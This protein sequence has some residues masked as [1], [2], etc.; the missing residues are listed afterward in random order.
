M[1]VETGL[2]RGFP[3][4]HP[5]VWRDPATGVAIPKGPVSNPTW[6]K[7]LL[8]DAER[9][10]AYQRALTALAAK[11]L[12]FW[13]NTFGYTY[14]VIE[15]VNGR[16]RPVHSDDAYR[17]FITWPVQDPA[18]LKIQRN[19]EE[20]K[21]LCIDKSRDMGASWLLVSTFVWFWLFR[22]DSKFLIV[23]RKEDLV[24]KP[25]DSDSLFWKMDMLVRRLPWWMRPNLKRASMHLENRQNGAVIDGESTNENIGRGGRRTAIA[26]DEAAAIPKLGAAISA[27]GPAAGCLIYNSTPMGPGAYS[28]VRFSGMDVVV[29]GYW[30]HP[31]KGQGREVRFDPRVGREVWWTPWYEAEWTEQKRSRKYMAQ[32]VLIDHMTSGT[33]VFDSDVLNRQLSACR[34]PSWR[35]RIEMDVDRVGDLDQA[36]RRGRVGDI[37]L[38]EDHN[39]PLR[40]WCELE[41]DEDGILRPRQDLDYALGG[42]VALGVSASNSALSIGVCNWR[43]KIGE[44][45]DANT[46]PDDL[47]RVAVMLAL[48]LGGRGGGAL[49][50]WERNGPGGI[51]T[52]RIKRIGYPRLDKDRDPVTPTVKTK[53]AYGFASTGHSKEVILGELNGDMASGQFQNPSEDALREAGRYVYYETGGVGPAQM[54][55]ESAD[56]TATHGDRVIAD[57]VLNRAM[58]RSGRVKPGKMKY[59]YGSPGW[60]IAKEE[61]E[62]AEAEEE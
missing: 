60:H 28:D 39:G 47:A 41:E 24:D 18:L 27:A 4:E 13:I 26:F 49:V 50:S 40:L 37:E 7:S 9:D 34:P 21:P 8:I 29:L 11:S 6:R 48:W 30:D 53:N 5:A 54:E 46:S 19:I 59:P 55:Q 57:A 2:Q 62:E 61:A 10:P 51:F 17:P 25:G 45:V 23:S 43:R 38:V 58:K 1:I 36:L 16:T 32:N 52:S 14:R 12:L 56:A 44:W 35:G 3:L 31:E 22:P 20:G 33:M 15:V 42:D